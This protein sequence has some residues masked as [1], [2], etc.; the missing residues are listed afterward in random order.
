MEEVVK[1]CDAIVWP[2]PVFS[3]LSAI[4]TLVVSA[5]GDRILHHLSYKYRKI[6]RYSTRIKSW[7]Q[8][9]LHCT[10]AIIETGFMENARKQ[11]ETNDC[12]NEDHKEDQEC[13]VEERYHC[14]DN[15]VE[16]NL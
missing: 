9:I 2:L 16:H 11:L 4:W 7:I 15:T 13:D 6:K 3:T 12:I 1:V 5:T 10:C 14:H 8:N